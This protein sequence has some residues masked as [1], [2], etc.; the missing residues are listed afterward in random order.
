MIDKGSNELQGQ[1]AVDDMKRQRGPTI[2]EQNAARL[3]SPDE[4]SLLLN[5]KDM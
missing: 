2:I 1:W 4:S 3:Q 5:I